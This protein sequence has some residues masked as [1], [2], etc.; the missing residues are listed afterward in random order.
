MN[1]FCSSSTHSPLHDFVVRIHAHTFFQ[2]LFV[3]SKSFTTYLNDSRFALFFFSRE[4]CK[5]NFFLEYTGHLYKIYN[6]NLWIKTLY[7]YETIC[8]FSFFTFIGCW[9]YAEAKKV[10]PFIKGDLSDRTGNLQ[11]SRLLWQNDNVSGATRGNSNDKQ[12]VAHV[13]LLISIN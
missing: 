1:L 4:I 11:V 7:V 6:L 9:F 10:D 13:L 12:I 3:F 5:F 8:R 2:L